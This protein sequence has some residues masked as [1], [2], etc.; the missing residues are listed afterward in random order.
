VRVARA[1]LAGVGPAVMPWPVV[2]NGSL[3]GV[4]QLSGAVDPIRG[5]GHAAVLRIL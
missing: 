2:P 4:A 1:Y 5:P 3:L